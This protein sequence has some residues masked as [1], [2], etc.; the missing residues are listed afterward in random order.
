M[1]LVSAFPGSSDLSLYPL[2]LPAVTVGV[3]GNTRYALI[4][5]GCH[6]ICPYIF[7]CVRY[8]LRFTHYLPYMHAQD[9]R[10]VRL[11]A[12]SIYFPSLTLSYYI[13]SAGF[14]SHLPLPL[15]ATN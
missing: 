3:F 13:I 15:M 2:P 8:P 1:I 10:S 9:T 14:L 12:G 7:M 6:R 4:M 5:P 11:A